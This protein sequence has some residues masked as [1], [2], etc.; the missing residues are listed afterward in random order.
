MF[1]NRGGLLA[2]A[3]LS[4]SAG[5]A[6]AGEVEDFY[7]ARTAA[8]VVGHEAGTGFDLYSR[9]LARHFGKSIPGKPNVTV[10]NMPGASALTA[11]NWLF[12]IAP[13]DGSVLGN[14][15]NTA[16]FEP[17]MG[18]AAARFDPLRFEWIGNMA[19]ALPICW[20]SNDAGIARFDE[21]LARE[22]QF[23][24]AAV[25]G[26]LS[27]MS[28]A[29]KKLTGARIKL[30]PGYRSSNEIKLAIQRGEVAGICGLPLAT[31]RSEWG[32][33]LE[34]GRLKPLIQLARANDPGLAGVPSIYDYAATDADRRV[35]DLIFG[36]QGLSHVY[37]T[38][39]GVP[40]PRLA[41]LRQAFLDT[42][43]DP[44]F[45]ADAQSQRLDISPSSGEEV[46]RLVAQAYEASPS[47]IERAKWA[48]R[49]D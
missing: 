13:R 4:L 49:G 19:E 35:F 12:N 8:I 22:V 48:V 10:Q 29:V 15:V 37:F 32:D 24:G 31:A 6:R 7:R 27:Q 44:A 39:P 21:L 16:I 45:L 17:L 18:D 11:A 33:L 47:E 5:L 26:T 30:T 40:T 20:V 38:P 36:A 9:V 14:V 43:A 2:F 42:L 46:A 25:A 41:A 1:A 3:A 34:S 23:G 28:N